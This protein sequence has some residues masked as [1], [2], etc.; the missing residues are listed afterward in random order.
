MNRDTGV[1][2]CPASTREAEAGELQGPDQPRSH[3]ET[4]SPANKDYARRSN[5]NG[6]MFG[7]LG[8]IHSA[9]KERK[10]KGKKKEIQPQIR[11]I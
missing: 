9:A 2:A 4:L 8:S 3:R 1:E 5:L 10:R 11:Q 7:T 6:R